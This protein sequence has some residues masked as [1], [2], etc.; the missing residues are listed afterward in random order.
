[1]DADNVKALFRRGRA[2][3]QRGR[4]IECAVA[5]LSHAHRISPQDDV[6]AAALAQAGAALRA[7]DYASRG[8]CARM[9]GAKV[10]DLQLQS[11][12]DYIRSLARRRC[13]SDVMCECAAAN[14]VCCDRH[15]Q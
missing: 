14:C 12:D 6:I 15:E 10:C 2:H 8:M 4:D 13:R 9:M 3:M 11:I 1:M 5:D 7:A